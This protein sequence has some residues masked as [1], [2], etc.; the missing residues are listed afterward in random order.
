MAYH[1]ICTHPVHHHELNRKFEKGEQVTDSQ[2]V[3]IL[4]K[5]HPN[6][7]VRV[8][9]VNSLLSDGGGRCAG[10]LPTDHQWSVHYEP[11]RRDRRAGQGLEELSL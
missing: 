2:H 5:E 4:M 10:H 8:L 1:L 3:D 9:R 11:C 6:R 7:F